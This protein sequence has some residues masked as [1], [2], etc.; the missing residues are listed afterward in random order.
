M[1]LGSEILELRKRGF[2]VTRIS[3]IVKLSH[4]TITNWLTEF[5]SLPVE[6]QR[7]LVRLMDQNSVFNLKDNMERLFIQTQTMTKFVE[8]NPELYTKYIAE[9]R[10]QLQMA[11]DILEKAEKLQMHKL[12]LN[13]ILNV[14]GKVD[15]DVRVLILKELESNPE[16][17]GFLT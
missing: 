5:D 1:G 12:A 3:N 17:R 13:T 6:E 16:I 10:K 14:I 8:D 11:S 7:E 2:P 4:S 15:D 9:Q